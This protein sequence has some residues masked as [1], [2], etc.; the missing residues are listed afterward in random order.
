MPDKSFIDDLA[1]L[2][3]ND[4]HATTAGKAAAPRE[5]FPCESC[6]GTGRY[7]GVRIHQEAVECF[8]CKGKGYF[9]KS[10]A[11]R[12]A[13]RAKAADRKQARID[14]GLTA[15]A[16]ANPGLLEGMR[17]HASWNDF[18]RDLLAKL[19]GG[20][21][22]SGNA[23]AAAQR[24]IDKAN[25]RDADRAAAARARVADAPRLDVDKLK[26][27]IESAMSAGLK[28]PVLRYDGFQVSR[29]PD[30]GKNAGALYVKAGDTYLGKIADGRYIATREATEMG[31]VPCVVEAMSDPLA[32]AIA[33]GRRT[34]QC[35]CCGRE[36]TDPVSVAAGIG[37]ICAG[38]FGW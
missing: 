11:D 38:K 29:A 32:S 28:R 7:R 20:T 16:A 34:G 1:D 6:L 22:L 14:N 4:L 2:P 17:K 3:L 10:Y 15:F 12:M 13:A 31:M 9:F 24:T 35:S 18:L 23:I 26:A 37:P 19:E 33:Y 5:T 25:A 30:H 21:A 8:A 36:L 27:S